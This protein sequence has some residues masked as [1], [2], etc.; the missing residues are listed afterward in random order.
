MTHLLSRATKILLTGATSGIG[1]GLCEK[2]LGA[3]HRVVAVSRTAD[4][5]PAH[6]RLQSVRCDLSKPS[7]VEAVAAGLVADH[8]DASLLINNAAIQ[9]DRRLGDPDLVPSMLASEAMINL[10]APALLA[11]T[12]LPLFQRA[13]RPAG[14][15]NMSSGLAFYPKRDTALYCATK[16]GL[17]SLSQSLRY[18]CEGTNVRVIEVVLPLVDTP[19]TAGRGSG[20]LPVSRV[21]NDVW[22]GLAGHRDEI[23]IGKAKLL[24]SI[25]AIAPGLA[26]KILKGN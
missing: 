11:H 20:K 2:F 4:A 15:V 8:P 17:H 5:L 26:R 14:I 18:A 23:Y 16:A 6:P 13:G 25:G 1:A 22:A 3:G 24:K 12:L 9:Y 21:V 19:M 10:V 7:D